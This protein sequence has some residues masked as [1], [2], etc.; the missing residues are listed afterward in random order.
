MQ[1]YHSP[2]YSA[3]FSLLLLI[4]VSV[5]IYAVEKSIQVQRG[6]S[7]RDIAQKY[8]GDA[9]LWQTI[10]EVN[11]LPS[12]ASI[13]VGMR[14]QIPGEI[15]IRVNKKLSLLNKRIRRATKLQARLFA[16]KEITNAILF[17]KQVL[18]F[19]KANRWQESDELLD[20]A[21]RNVDKAIKVCI[22]KQDEKAEAVLNDKQGIVNWQ[23]PKKGNWLQAK[24]FET[25]LEGDK[26][27]TLSHSF[28]EI[29]FRDESKL[30]LNSNSQIIIKQSRSNLLKKTERTTVSVIKG[31]V[32]A[33]L[34]KNK[35]NKFEVKVP[36]MEIKTDS[37]NFY[38]KRDK[39][40]KTKIANYDGE[41]KIV[42]KHKAVTIKKDQGI[43][44][45]KKGM[46]KPKKLLPSPRLLLPE[47]E[48]VIYQ[49]HVVFKWQKV[50]GA[51]LYWL[52][53]AND[54]N[55]SKTM[56]NANRLTKTEFKLDKLK[57]GHYYWRLSVL[58]KD[59]FPSKRSRAFHFQYIKDDFPPYL[60]ITQPENRQIVKQKQ[61]VVAGEVEPGAVLEYQHKKLAVG[62]DGHF[63]VKVRLHQG[64]NKLRF[65]AV[66]A[67]GN[68]TLVSH[69]LDYQ[70]RKKLFAFFDTALV[71]SGKN[72][73]IAMGQRFTLAA[74]TLPY[75]KVA[76]YQK[77]KRLVSGYSDAKGKIQLTFDLPSDKGEYRLLIDG[78]GQQLEQTLTIEIDNQPPELFMDNIKSLVRNPVVRLSGQVTGASSLVINEKAVPVRNKHFS[79]DK[80]LNAGENLFVLHARDRVGNQ[81][82]KL[83]RVIYD[84]EPPELIKWSIK[85]QDIDHKRSI[86]VEAWLKE[87]FGVVNYLP[88]ELS[89]GR[90]YYT[91][92]LRKQGKNHY[93]TLVY[94]PNKAPYAQI[95]SLT[96]EDKAGNKRQV[97]INKPV[98]IKRQ[99]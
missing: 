20:Q 53:I 12:A 94:L 41:M 23:D 39:N 31:D 30:R 46:S 82:N 34:N 42:H 91:G 79:V 50:K 28:A 97:R 40:G 15:V 78:E 57:E 90:F 6:Q 96:L 68:D 1:K 24:L 60:V 51:A 76:L 10:L 9:E 65:K 59:G 73:F 38:V 56:I 2:F 88:F 67:A 26:I 81:V 70:P 52:E 14:L 22:K 58:D 64:L 44:I 4:A 16:N 92:L 80:Q 77:E 61:V 72:H 37:K 48:V 25:F 11:H 21:I 85:R 17:Q 47:D 5:D 13:R 66:D 29:L 43:F 49:N 8:L 84:L 54:A 35:N 55:F 99:Q 27:R 7:I 32:F 36:G 3:L 87:P 63:S 71:R 45:S 75:S 95:I 69:Y 74:E 18:L 83:I 89:S 86:L 33:L 62:A 93:S 98:K 19:K